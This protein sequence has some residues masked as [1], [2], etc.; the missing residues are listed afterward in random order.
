MVEWLDEYIQLHSSLK[1]FTY[2]YIPV[3]LTNVHFCLEINSIIAKVNRLI[4]ANIVFIN[5]HA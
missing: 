3:N 5:M 4:C 1:C 2:L